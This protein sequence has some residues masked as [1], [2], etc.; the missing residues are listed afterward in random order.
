MSVLVD[1]VSEFLNP[2]QIA[3]QIGVTAKTV[4]EWLNAGDL[5]GIKIGKSWRVH[6]RDLDRL[7]GEQLFKARLERARKVHPDIT[8]VRGQCRQCGELMPE[9]KSWGH[10]VCSPECKEK[11]DYATATILD[12]GTEEYTMNCAGV[13]P[14]F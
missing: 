1:A 2:E 12:I 4:R 10:W 8:W 14:P 11:Y 13:T 5:I 9:P 6:R 3:D 7:I